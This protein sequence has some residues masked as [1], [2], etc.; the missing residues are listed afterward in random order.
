LRVDQKKR[1]KVSLK[2]PNSLPHHVMAGKSVTEVKVDIDKAG[3]FPAFL[4]G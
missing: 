4:L 2:I 1:A 3:K